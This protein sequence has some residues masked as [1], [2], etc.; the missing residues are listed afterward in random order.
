MLFKR[1]LII[2]A[3]KSRNST[4][5]IESFLRQH[6][7]IKTHSNQQCKATVHKNRSGYQGGEY[8]DFEEL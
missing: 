3:H 2:E 4:S 5:T 6:E 1:A 8:I 7:N